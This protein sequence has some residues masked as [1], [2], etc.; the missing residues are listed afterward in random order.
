MADEMHE[1]ILVFSTSLHTL[2]YIEGQLVSRSIHVN[3][4]DGKTKAQGRQQLTKS[5]NS[6]QGANIMLISTRAGGVGLNITA[7]TRVVIFDFDFSPQDE[8]QAIARAYRLGQEKPVYVY[9][10]KVGGTFEDVIHNK[11][12]FKISLAA[13]VVD[14]SN[15][16]KL[17]KQGRAKEYFNPPSRCIQQ[18]LSEFKKNYNDAI[19]QGLIDSGLVMG[20]DL[21]DTYTDE[22]DK[23]M[24]Q[25]EKERFQTD[26]ENFN[27][28]GKLAEDKED[29]ENDLDQNHDSEEG[30]EGYGG[31]GSVGDDNEGENEGEAGV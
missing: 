31:E 8:E 22:G 19:L 23:N 13:R 15:P 17:A 28:E 20:I 27:N 29:S 30:E 9:R 21:Q 11:S 1:K 5:F 26:L 6:S 10:F 16:V 12:L 25:S 7:A 14:S 4:L 24:S 2:D 3:R 18:D